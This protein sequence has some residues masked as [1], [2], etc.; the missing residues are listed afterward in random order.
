[1]SI[2]KNLY[3]TLGVN[4]NAKKEDIKKAFREKAKKLHPDTSKE[5]SQEEF[6]E[7]HRAYAILVD[8]VRRKKYDS[9]GS[10][11]DEKTLES[12]MITIIND[13]FVSTV[14]D[15]NF[16]PDLNDPFLVIKTII[17]SK[18]N[19]MK[20]SIEKSNILIKKYERSIEKIISGKNKEHFVQLLFNLIEVTKRRIELMKIELD[21]GILM[22]NYIDGHKWK[23]EV[24]VVNSNNLMFADNTFSVEFYQ[25]L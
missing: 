19:E 18:Q 21:L 17:N 7:V 8:E 12:R 23:K 22:L 1:M 24:I 20:N 4:K 9:T 10:I 13:M 6:I 5:D 2:F 11:E 3:E 25:D 15:P 16:N 14:N